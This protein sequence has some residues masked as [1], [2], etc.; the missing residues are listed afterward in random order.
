MTRDE[1]IFN[2]RKQEASLRYKV[3]SFVIVTIV[4]T[5]FLGLFEIGFSVDFGGRGESAS[6]LRFRD[7][8]LGRSWMLKAEENGPFP[9]R[10]ELG[11]YGN[12]LSLGSMDGLMGWNDYRVQLRP[13]GDDKGYSQQELAAKGMRVFP[14][15]RDATRRADP[16][17][18]GDMRQT[19][20]L[21]PYDSG[22]L[23]WMPEKLPAFEMPLN[24]NAVPASWRF[25]VNLRENGTVRESI[26]L[27]GGADAGQ[28]A[29]ET[30]LQGVRFK[31]GTGD[32]WLGLR[33]EI[34]NR[35]KNGTEPE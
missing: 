8:E 18:V 10:L 27:G 13:L 26:S 24:E 17:E 33:V 25:T 11:E 29:M 19:P 5:I 14:S 12:Q 4:F 3:I 15:R 9:G 6:V 20:I 7:D 2:W 35:K 28:A 34:I 21:F 1:L 30:W 23:K 32:R 22:A 31:E 16:P